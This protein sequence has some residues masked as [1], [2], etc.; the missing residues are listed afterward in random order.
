MCRL[1]KAF[2]VIGHQIAEGGVAQPHRLVEHCIE[3]RREIAGRRIDHLQDLGRG[4]L[5]F[6]GLVPLIGAFV[7]PPLQLSVGAP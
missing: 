3:H 6:Q 2:A 5:L 1:L 4:G 7:Q